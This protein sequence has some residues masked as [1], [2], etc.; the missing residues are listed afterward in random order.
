MARLRRE[1]AAVPGA[2]LFL[3]AVQDIRVGG[4]ALSDQGKQGVGHRPQ[5]TTPIVDA[6]ETDLP[7]WPDHV[8][9]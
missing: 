8:C 5:A 4:R 2:T 7:V 9:S 1:M 6:T 3:Q